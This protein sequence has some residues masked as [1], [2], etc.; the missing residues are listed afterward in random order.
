MITFETR[1]TRQTGQRL[2]ARYRPTLRPSKRCS[3]CQHSKHIK[4]GS[5]YDCAKF[6]LVNGQYTCDLNEI[7]D[8]WRD[9]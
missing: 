4:N 7:K 9:K 3:R 5:Q 6:G 2:K 1:T 8:K